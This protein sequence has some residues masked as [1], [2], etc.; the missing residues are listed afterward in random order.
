M[1]KG[2]T[3]LEL[4][5]VISIIAILIS[6]GMTSFA[7]AQKKGR[8]AKRKG[9]IKSVQNALEQYYSVCGYQ[10]PTPSGTFF[11]PIIC[12]TPGVSIAVLPTVP[13]DPR[14]VT[15]YFCGPTPGA[16][17]CTATN[18][19]I[20]TMLEGETPATYCLSNNQ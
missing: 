16:S 19:T 5:V 20:C 17:N 12:T 13:A 3:L 4:L 2:F 14:A 8:D 9:D 7:T 18:F 1:K 15:P 11:S 6:V 10:Y